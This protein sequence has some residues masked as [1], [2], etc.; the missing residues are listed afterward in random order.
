MPRVIASTTSGKGLAGPAP[1]AFK[2]KIRVPRL[3]GAKMGVLATRTPHRPAP[4]G[5]SVAKVGPPPPSPRQLHGARNW[6]PAAPLAS[7]AQTDPHSWRAGRAGA[8]PPAASQLSF[9]S[10]SLVGTA[11]ILG[12]EGGTLILGGADIVDG[13][14]VL[15][16]KPYVPFCDSVPGA[17]APPWV[18]VGARGGTWC[19]NL[20]SRGFWKYRG[21]PGCAPV[22]GTWGVYQPVC[23]LAWG[24][25][26]ACA[27]MAT[28]ACLIVAVCNSPPG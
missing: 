19:V 22:R 5:L 28:P 6:A 2:A 3:D 23:S 18:K 24:A 8:R 25:V 15:D 4:I 9:L 1:T 27:L 21:G 14:P 12:V 7:A 16:I 13:S 17:S 10:E 26:R 11:Q 20:L